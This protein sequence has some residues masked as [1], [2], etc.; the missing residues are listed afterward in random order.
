VHSLSEYYVISVQYCVL[1]E[2]KKA[3]S[4]TATHMLW[5]KSVN[6]QHTGC[7][8]KVAPKVLC[9]FLRNRLAF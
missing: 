5:C 1:S 4:H 6:K 7:G 2:T 9:C 8:Q 3:Q